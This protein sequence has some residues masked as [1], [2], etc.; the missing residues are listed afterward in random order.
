M[1][2]S[3]PTNTGNAMGDA[4]CAVAPNRDH[5]ESSRGWTQNWRGFAAA[6]AAVAWL[7]GVTGELSN[8]SRLATVALSIAVVAGGSTFVPSSLRALH[9]G[10]IGVALLMTIAGAGAIILGQLSEAASLAFLFSVSEA[11]EELAITRSRR[12]LRAVLQLVPETSTVRRNGMVVDVPTNQVEI[13]DVIVLRAGARLST[14]GVIRD[15][16]SVIDVSAVNGESIPVESG[17]GDKIFAG[18]INGGGQ[19]D[20][21]ATANASEST[22]ARIVHAV[23]EAQDRKGRAQR[24]ADRIARPLVPAIMVVA[25]A[26]AVI[27]SLLGDPAVWI[28]RALVVLVAAAPCAF[29]ISVPVAVFAAIGSATST[30]MVV[31][32]GAALEALATV[33]VVAFDKTGTLT[34]NQP[35]VVDVATWGTD[36]VTVLGIAA[37]LEAHSNHPLADAITGSSAPIGDAADVV[38]LPGLGITGRV[39]GRD[40]RLGS[41]IFIPPGPLADDVQRMMEHG[42]T[43][44]VVERDSK[45]IGAIAVRDELRDEARHVVRELQ[46]LGLHVAMLSGDHH[47]TAHAGGIAAGITDVRAQLLPGDK[48]RAIH[49]LSQRGPVMMVGD[50]INDAPALASAAVGVAMGALGSDVAIEAADIAIMSDRLTHLPGLVLQARRTRRIIIQN[51]VMSGAI[52]ATLVPLAGAGLLGLG[53]VVAIHEG[54]EIIVIANGLRARRRIFSTPIAPATRSRNRVAAHV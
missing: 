29:A 13:G 46:E 2:D 36:A 32:G 28:E 9:Q 22:L 38:T 3:A 1:S 11:L 24:L 44:V 20:I 49:E 14:D 51:L 8:N 12:G 23:E 6:V 25:T 18:S 52:I 5:V 39:D 27:G 41:P 10:R 34:R 17:P 40:V 42:A 31:K 45:A 33:R 53:V 37:A 47:A 50:G 15:G 19:L 48:Q 35:V 16:R 30:G 21:V 4:C 54:A 26:V 7:I 43:V